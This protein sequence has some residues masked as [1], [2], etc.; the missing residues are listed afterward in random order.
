MCFNGASVSIPAVVLLLAPCVCLAAG[1]AVPP[2]AERF[3]KMF[4]DLRS[5]EAQPAASRRHIEV[6]FQE[7]EINEYLKYSLQA[8][9]RPGVESSTL[10]IFANNYISTVTLVDFDAIERWKPGTIPALLRP[11]LRGKHPVWVDYRFGTSNGTLTFS[12]E[13]AYYGD[14]RLPAILVQQMIAIVA[15]RQPEHY[16]T[17]KPLPLPFGLRHLW[18]EGQALK[19]AN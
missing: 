15:A 9:P 18:T 19:A 12:V 14:L 16:D 17:G 11:I 3:L 2:V 5:V 1:P 7:H 4:D 13:K 10:K 8:T 6:A